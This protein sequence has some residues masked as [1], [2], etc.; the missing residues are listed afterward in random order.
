MAEHEREFS[1]R[2]LGHFSLHEGDQEV[3]FSPGA[4][5]LI[6]FLGLWPS[7]HERKNLSTKL[8]PD[9]TEPRSLQNLR[10]VISEVRGAIPGLLDV[11]RSKVRLGPHLSTDLDPVFSL[12]ADNLEPLDAHAVRGRSLPP[13]WTHPLLE[14]WEEDW[15]V[16]PRTRFYE[17][18]INYLHQIGSSSLSVG[19]VDT[20]V[21]AGLTALQHDP[22]RETSALLVAEGH[23]AAGNPARARLFLAE[24]SELLKQDC[25]TDPSKSVCEMIA[26]LTSSSLLLPP[27]V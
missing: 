9:T 22:Y 12:G 11:S 26:A 24:F 15:L 18:R 27:T 13:V 5:R 8:W 1:L 14:D 23:V 20:A 19:D 10:N 16:G 25:L 4:Q 21:V 17:C 2:L 6:A 3:R 7:S